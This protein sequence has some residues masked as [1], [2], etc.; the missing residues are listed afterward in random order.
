MKKNENEC[1]TTPSSDKKK[2]RIKPE[3]N[4]VNQILDESKSVRKWQRKLIDKY[5][6]KRSVFRSWL[7]WTK[8]N[9]PE[10]YALLPDGLIEY[11]KRVRGTDEE[12][13]IVDAIE[14][15]LYENGGTYN[16]L[17]SYRSVIRSFFIHNRTEL[18]KDPTSRLKP[19]RI[20]QVAMFNI[21]EIRA[22]YS[23]SSPMIRA[24][25]M[26]LIMGG[27]GCD[28]LLYW[29]KTGYDSLVSQLD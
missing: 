5:E 17:R 1:G 13:R 4:E 28:E 3:Y 26:S 25:M 10:L 23:S 7:W 20:S 11:Q 15:W 27:M 18:P 9:E 8:D 19:T 22:I 12:F 2:A 21:N 14:G 16:T 29:N 6:S 24:V